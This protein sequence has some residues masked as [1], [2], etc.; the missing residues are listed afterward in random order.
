MISTAHKQNRNAELAEQTFRRLL[1]W[2]DQGVNTNGR[3]YLA[4]RDRLLAYFE[5]KNCLN[6]DQLADETL[7][8][9]ARRLDEEDGNI[10]T[11]IPAKYC[12]IVARF[13]F[14]E[15]LRAIEKENA[16]LDDIGRQ[17]NATS[18]EDRDR[19]EKMLECLDRCA[20]KLELSQRELIFGYYTGEQRVK[21]ENRH[22]LA[23]TLGI[24]VNALSIRACRIR[25][26]LEI[27]VKDC[28][29]RE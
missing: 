15:Y 21:I 27:C 3:S 19:K 24:T 12:Y 16:A 8:R 2:L 23:Q 17:A 26:K 10:E 22:S 7:N 6:A 28:A 1:T 14:M 25:D 20:A 29:S 4:I 11:E 9:V 13:V 18:R 5:R